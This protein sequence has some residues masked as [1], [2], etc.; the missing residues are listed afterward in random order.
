MR[1]GRRPLLGLVRQ[2][3]AGVVASPAEYP[4]AMFANF[5]GVWGGYRSERGEVVVAG[6][7]GR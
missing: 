1:I 5:F 3:G 4:L 7:D 2:L 6:N